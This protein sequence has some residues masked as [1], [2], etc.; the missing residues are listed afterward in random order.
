M[1]T[2][3]PGGYSTMPMFVATAEGGGQLE[4]LARVEDVASGSTC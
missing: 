3:E 4:V 2:V 1:A